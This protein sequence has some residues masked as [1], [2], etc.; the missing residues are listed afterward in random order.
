[1]VGDTHKMSYEGQ[2]IGPFRLMKQLHLRLL[3]CALTLFVIAAG[4]SAD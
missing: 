1:M 3:R 2:I 4:A